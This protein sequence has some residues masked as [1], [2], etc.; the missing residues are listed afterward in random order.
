MGIYV[1]NREVLTELLEDHPEHYDFGRELLPEALH[2]YRVAMHCFRGYWAD[3][4]TI[5]SFY[6]ANLALTRS[7]QYSLYNPDSPLYT[8]PRYL[9]PTRLGKA[10]VER[11]LI[12]EGSVIGPCTIRDSV[13]GVRSRIEDGV[14]LEGTL[15]M[16]NDLYET[17]AERSACRE[18]GIPPLGIGAGS[19]VRRAILDKGARIGTDVRIVNE[20]GLE[21]LDSD[22]CYIREGIVIIPRDGIVP[23]GTVI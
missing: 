8:R 13:I 21:H 23:D 11:A 4:G 1:F 22:L 18:R 9:S 3:I 2:H 5:S 19:I 10:D 6:S 17:E 7:G 15:V 14:T 12:A 16:G 20:R